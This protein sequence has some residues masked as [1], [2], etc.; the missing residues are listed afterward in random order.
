MF[1]LHT[2]V[3]FLA[4][5]AISL[6]TSALAEEKDKAP[7]IGKLMHKSFDEGGLRDQI[8]SAV[9]DK[10]FDVAAKAV[11]EWISEAKGLEN[12]T[13]P[14]DLKKGWTKAAKGFQTTLSTLE[15]AIDKKDAKAVEAAFKKINCGAC[16]NTFK[17]P[18]K[19]A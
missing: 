2:W 6:S 19:K 18:K 14:Q 10:D 5:A 8:K 3:A 12:A 7:E 11:K 16:H 1:R 15:K 9:K 4:V 13:P 17:L